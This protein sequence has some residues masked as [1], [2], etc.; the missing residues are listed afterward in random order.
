MRVG[1]SRA[2][3]IH[4]DDGGKLPGNA[5]S[6]FVPETARFFEDDEK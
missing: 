6:Y 4:L 1:E 2:R 5:V 3:E